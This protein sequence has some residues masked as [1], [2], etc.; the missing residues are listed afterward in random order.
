MSERRH[1]EGLVEARGY[2]AEAYGQEARA[3]SAKFAARSAIFGAVLGTAGAVGGAYAGAK[4][5]K[6]ES[7]L[8]TLQM[9][10]YGTRLRNAGPRIGRP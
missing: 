9:D 5:R 10:Y 7:E 8:R 1:Y 2:E 6:T 3:D 4:T